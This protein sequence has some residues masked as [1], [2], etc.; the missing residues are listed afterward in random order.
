[1]AGKN[2]EV[3]TENKLSRNQKGTCAAKTP[4]ASWVALGRR[5]ME[6]VLSLHSALLRPH[7][8]HCVQFWL[9]GYETDIDIPEQDQ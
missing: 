1:M 3:L 2:M 6:A 7:L 9:P 8:D 4:N 5:L